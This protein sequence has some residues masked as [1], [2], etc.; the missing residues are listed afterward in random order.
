MP[1]MSSY[2]ESACPNE[3]QEERKLTKFEGFAFFKYIAT[4]LA[5]VDEVVRVQRRFHVH[6]GGVLS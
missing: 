1:A 3:R 2:S 6:F 4:S 5:R